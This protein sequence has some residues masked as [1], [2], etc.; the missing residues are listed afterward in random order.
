M[1]HISELDATGLLQHPAEWHATR[2]LGIGGSD[3]VTI[4]EAIP[5]NLERLRLGKLGRVEPED[6]S[7]RLPVQMGS[8]TEPLNR[9]W[10]SRAIGQHVRPGHTMVSTQHPFMRANIDGFVHDG[11]GIAECKHVNDFTKL[12]G[13]LSKYYPQLQHNL[14]VSGASYCYL[15]VFFGSGR[16]E[17]RMVAPDDD[18]I[19]QLIAREKSFWQSVLEDRP[20]E[21]APLPTPIPASDMREVDMK[22]SNAWSVHAADW[23]ALRQPAKRF[24]QVT[25]EL[26]SFMEHDV[27][28]AFGSG[29]EVVRDSRGVSVR[30]LKTNLRLTST[31]AKDAADENAR[32]E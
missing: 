13:A 1:T 12:D 14:S 5:A 6:L 32:S 29:I 23:I 3:A 9:L 18:Y 27:R 11:Y 20:Y 17:W 30:E 16:F 22:G 4:T 26:K 25:K 10:L 31:Q 19:A 21:E 15:S 24:E 8:W 2:A 28:R 7:N